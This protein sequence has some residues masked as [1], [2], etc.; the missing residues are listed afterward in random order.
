VVVWG[1][2]QRAGYVNNVIVNNRKSGTTGE[3]TNVGGVWGSAVNV[4]ACERKGTGRGSTCVNRA[5][6]TR[7]QRES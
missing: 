1:I 6:P 2:K 7:E 3:V 4:R 5:G